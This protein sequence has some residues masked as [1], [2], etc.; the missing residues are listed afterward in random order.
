VSFAMYNTTE[1]IDRLL[2]GLQ[3]VQEMHR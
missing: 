3:K 1:E 2:V